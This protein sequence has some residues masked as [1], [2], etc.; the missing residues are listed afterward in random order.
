MLPLDL[1]TTPSILRRDSSKRRRSNGAGAEASVVLSFESPLPTHAS[2]VALSPSVFFQDILSFPSPIN[3]GFLTP[4][5]FTPN[6]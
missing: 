3:R 6:R 4:N 1:S 5:R 2:P